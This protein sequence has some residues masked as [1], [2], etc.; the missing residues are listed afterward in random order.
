MIGPAFGYLPA[1]VGDDLTFDHI[2]ALAAQPHLARAAL[3]SLRLVSP[4]R[5]TI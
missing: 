1:L 4:E 3:I 5:A 2:A